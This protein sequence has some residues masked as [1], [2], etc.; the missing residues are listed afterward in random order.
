MKTA[1]K[2]VLEDTAHVY[3]RSK[4]HTMEHMKYNFIYMILFL[5]QLWFYDVNHWYFFVQIVMTI[6]HRIFLI[7][8]QGSV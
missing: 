5:Y 7:M 1:V 4:Q 2:P 8:S 6:N 3:S